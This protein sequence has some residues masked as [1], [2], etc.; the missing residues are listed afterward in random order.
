MMHLRAPKNIL[1]EHAPSPPREPQ[2][3]G[4][5]SP[6]LTV[7]E[8]ICPTPPPPPQ[9]KKKKTILVLPTP[10]HDSW[11]H[12]VYN[13]GMFSFLGVLADRIHDILFLCTDY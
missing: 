11:D 10:M 3:A 8:L 6:T 5:F 12:V 7:T 4:T 1:E 9:K 13:W 2:A